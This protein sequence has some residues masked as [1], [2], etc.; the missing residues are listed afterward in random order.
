MKETSR[1][2][3][4]RSAARNKCLSAGIYDDGTGMMQYYA[5]DCYACD[6]CSKEEEWYLY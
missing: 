5:D 4:V 6:V 2:K 1:R 3:F